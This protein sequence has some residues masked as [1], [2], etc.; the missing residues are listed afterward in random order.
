M[1]I[2][3]TGVFKFL[4]YLGI[5][6]AITMG[7]FS[8][9]AT[10]EDDAADLVAIPVDADYD[11]SAGEVTVDKTTEYTAAAEEDYGNCTDALSVNGLLA[12]HPNA[13]DIDKV[14]IDKITYKGEGIQARYKDALTDPALQNFTC[15][16]NFKEI[17]EPL[18]F[19]ERAKYD[20]SVPGLDI[21]LQDPAWT[22]Y[23]VL[24]PDQTAIDALNY[25]LDYR[26]ATF[27]VCAICTIEV[28]DA[29]LVSVTAEVVLPVN[30][31]GEI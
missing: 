20:V 3:R 31:K 14:S 27:K 13:E 16:V 30:L 1:I 2:Q 22:D 28:D 17:S 11:L 7:F 8:I 12:S 4:R 24:T 15:K 23:I 25:F 6:C 29:D 21:T 19:P 10:S 9:V 5:F 26:D 18:D